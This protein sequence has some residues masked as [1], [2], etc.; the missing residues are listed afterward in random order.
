MFKPKTLVL[1]F[2][3]GLLLP[4]AAD[5]AHKLLFFTKSSGFEHEVISWKKG[6]P[7]HSEKIFLELGSK[8]SWTFEFSKDGSKFSPEY[9]AGFDAVIFYTTG[10]LTSP[11]TD[12]QPPMTP[13]GKQALFDYV[14]SGKGFIGIHSASDTFHTANESKKGPDRYVNHGKDADPYVCFLGGEFIIHGEQQTATCKVVDNKFPGF[15]E[16]GDS[17]AFKEEWYS[18]KDFRSDIH[19][20][21]VID[22]PAMKG[23][24]YDR[25]PFP[26]TWARKEG[27][28]RIYYTALGHRDDVW[29]NPTFQNMLVGAIRWTTGEVDAAVPP[30][31]KEAAP[32]AMK[33]PKFPEPKK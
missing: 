3:L 24:M 11:G 31:L 10:D 13:E 6:Q 33:N 8:H 30:N 29:T 28:G 5:P 2:G 19:A 27:K 22:S 4:A 7:S 9:L 20:L 14:K 26:N 1:A 15:E 21:T 23:S 17:F 18:L 25:P 12:K 16:A 32:G